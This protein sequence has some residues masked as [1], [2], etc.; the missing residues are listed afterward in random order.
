VFRQ[1]LTRMGRQAGRSIVSTSQRSEAPTPTRSTLA[2]PR[3]R[4][5]R[6]QWGAL[7]LGWHVHYHAA[8]YKYAFQ[9]RQRDARPKEG[10]RAAIS[11]KVVVGEPPRA[12][13]VGVAI[14]VGDL[15][16]AAFSVALLVTIVSL[17]LKLL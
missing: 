14:M 10:R 13:R 12:A 15:L 17:P 1:V 16:P 11:R 2:D 9:L 8:C 4:A 5:A 3:R 6:G 7:F